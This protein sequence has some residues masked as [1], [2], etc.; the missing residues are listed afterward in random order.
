V[1][2]SILVQAFAPF[3]ERKEREELT[4]ELLE[5]AIHDNIFYELTNITNNLIRDIDGCEDEEIQDAFKTEAIFAPKC[6]ERKRLDSY[7]KQYANNIELCTIGETDH[8]ASAFKGGRKKYRSMHRR[9]KH[10][11]TKHSNKRN[12][13]KTY[14]QHIKSKSNKATKNRKINR[15]NTMKVFRV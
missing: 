8:A 11:I 7:V 14:K 12:N 9:T 10:K 4:P 5:K 15:K 1:H 3:G 6:I 2:N 13:K